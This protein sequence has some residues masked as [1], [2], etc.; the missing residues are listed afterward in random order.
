[1]ADYHWIVWEIMESMRPRWRFFVDTEAEAR[2]RMTVEEYL[3][4]PW[5]QLGE[6][7]EWSLQKGIGIMNKL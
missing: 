2:G 4:H 6:D 7:E 1:M 3:A 5:Y